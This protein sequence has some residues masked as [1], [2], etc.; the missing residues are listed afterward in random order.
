MSSK[1][2]QPNYPEAFH[3]GFMLDNEEQVRETLTKLKSGG[4]EVGQ[5]PIKIRDSFGFYFNFD[6]FMIEVG[7]YLS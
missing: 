3:I 2:G 7:Y 1:S 4:I 6:N 5:E